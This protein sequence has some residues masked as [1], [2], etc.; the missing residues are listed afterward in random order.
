MIKEAIL[1]VSAS[2]LR[3]GG[4]WFV[5]VDCRVDVDITHNHNAMQRICFEA[6]FVC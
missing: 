4:L 3:L 2:S 5:V 1:N 6:C